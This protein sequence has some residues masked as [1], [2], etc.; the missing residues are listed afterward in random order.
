MWGYTMQ[1]FEMEITGLRSDVNDKVSGAE[2]MG[3]PQGRDRLTAW[4]QVCSSGGHR[5]ACALCWEPGLPTHRGT[6]PHPG[7]GA[8]WGQ[9][10]GP[11]LTAGPILALTIPEPPAQ[12]GATS[13]N[14]KKKPLLTIS[15]PSLKLRINCF[16]SPTQ[17]ICKD[18]ITKYKELSRWK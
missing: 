6:Q 15:T 14:F 13:L 7:K 9:S 5:A 17:K 10:S 2:T 11:G 3:M 8:R 12:Q 18:W 16:L 4:N 1:T